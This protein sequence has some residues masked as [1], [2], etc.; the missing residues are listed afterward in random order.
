MSVLQATRKYTKKVIVDIMP[1]DITNIGGPSTGTRRRIKHFADSDYLIFSVVYKPEKN[2]DILPN[3]KN[4]HYV[5]LSNFYKALPNF[6]TKIPYVL[7]IFFLTT[8]LKIKHNARVFHAHDIYAA[9]AC[10]LAKFFFDIKVTITFHGPPSYEMMHFR[11]K[12][13]LRWRLLVPVVRIIERAVC[14]WVDN[15]IAVSEFEKRFIEK[16]VSQKNINVI[17]NSVNIDAFKPN[18]T[19]I[20]KI[21][22]DKKIITFVGRLVRKNGPVVIINAIPI[23]ISKFEHVH[24]V[25]VGDGELEEELKKY[26]T[27]NNLENFVTFLGRRYDINRLLNASDIFVSHCS[28]LVEG[29]GNNVIEAL[30]SGLPCV[31]GDD[32]VTRNIFRNYENGILTK[33]D[34][35]KDIALSI[36][37]LLNDRKLYLHISIEA[38]KLA[39]EV[40]SLETQMKK[41]ERV[42]F[43]DVVFRD[44]DSASI[45]VKKK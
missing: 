3:S 14:K 13:K 7:N 37:K 5:F 16:Y 26:I 36:L 42:L 4:I 33:K 27:D 24:F 25:F 31:I 38:R 34:D 12:V 44:V 41:L 1:E 40:F 6:I 39:E 22:S 28:S 10:C 2:P 30:A 23:V 15:I 21:P 17:R 8:L 19:N 29:I 43:K 45:G 20:D 18:K 9:F 11:E 35:P 32:Y